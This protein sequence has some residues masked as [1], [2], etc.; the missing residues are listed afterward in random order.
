MPAM[1][2]SWEWHLCGVVAAGVFAIAA[3][4]K[5][6]QPSG[7]LATLT[8]LE[9]VSAFGLSERFVLL[10]LVGF[11]AALAMAL[12]VG[13]IPE[14]IRLLA[15]SVLLVFASVLLYLFLQ[16][17]PI[18]CGCAGWSP[19]GV[20]AR[21]ELAIGMTKNVLLATL[22]VTSVRGRGTND[23]HQRQVVSASAGFTLIETIVVV[24]VVAVLVA[25]SL[26]A[27]RG[28]REAGRSTRS[29]S[30]HRQLAA[31][32]GTYADASAGSYPY[33]RSAD[34]LNLDHTPVV[35]IATRTYLWAH[36]ILRHDP[37]VI[38]ILY[39]PEW[40]VRAQSGRWDRPEP[41]AFFASGT[42]FADPE[43]FDPEIEPLPKHERAIRSH[44]V[45][46]PSSKMLFQDIS[47]TGLLSSGDVSSTF[48]FVDASAMV[49]GPDGLDG[50]WV[51]RPNMF[52]VG[53]GHSTLHGVQGRDK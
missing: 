53:P 50:D 24:A 30:A 16:D 28:V 14:I 34:F 6:L 22:L 26:P 31:S 10:F 4:G 32:W 17:E 23:I 27:L 43:Y 36:H 1:K 46:Y 2:R 49:V 42:F 29:L 51:V 39:P 37:D 20:G 3:I 19:P 47:R 12:L 33:P 41:H 21:A 52:F 40:P 48:A 44:E 15:A 25:I 5:A 7:F 9:F 45:V 8:E 13:V 11:E 35:S 18:R 38:H